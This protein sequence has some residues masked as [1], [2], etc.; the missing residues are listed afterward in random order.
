MIVLKLGGSVVT[1]KDRA[2]TLDG[3]ALDRAADAVADALAV[4]SEA[5]AEG[6]VV[7]HGGGSFGHHNASEHGVS[8]IAGTRD[9]TAV[10]DIHGAMTTLNRFVLSRLLERDVPAV[11]VHPFSAGHRDADGEFHLPTGQVA[12]LLAEGFVP[13]LHGDVIAHAGE[14]V[15]IVS[16]DELVAELARALEADR[17]GLCS[18]VP[19]VLDADDR[20]VERIE[21]YGTVADVLGESESTDVT[22]GM[23]AKVRA[24]L[25]L[26]ADASIFG[27]EELE[28]FLEGAE[29]GTTIE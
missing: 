1:D 5:L 21:S 23:A 19:G 16:G 17:I 20:V 29:P 22:G 18:T 10:H 14:G 2:E 6:L 12:T 11:P 28:G 7:V 3:E 13:V 26:E 15:T 9:P 8:T 25:E 24:L 27:L 4:P